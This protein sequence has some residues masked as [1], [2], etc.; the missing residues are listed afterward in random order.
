MSGERARIRENAAFLDRSVS[1]RAKSTAADTWGYSRVGLRE[2]HQRLPRETGPRGFI[3]KDY[4]TLNR[5]K[6][7]S[8]ALLKAKC[9]RNLTAPPQNVLHT[10]AAAS[11]LRADDEGQGSRLRTHTRRSTS[12]YIKLR[13]VT[14]TVRLRSG[15]STT[16]SWIS[17]W[18]A[19]NGPIS[20]SMDDNPGIFSGVRSL[21]LTFDP[22]SYR[23]CMM[24]LRECVR[25][26]GRLPQ[27]IVI[28]GAPSSKAPILKPSWRYEC[29][30]K[31]GLQ[32]RRFGS[33]CERL[34]GTTNTQ[35]IHNLEATPR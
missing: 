17:N 21:Y 30:K 35:F 34:F 28:D 9:E 4:E 32:R 33:V 23:A 27:I 1:R 10:D 20:A 2:P 29:I 31:A 11:G 18:C 7:S 13:L 5:V 6:L 8:W 26:H 24:I 12:N 15:T 19:R 14:E 3:A 22:P 25:R 16:L